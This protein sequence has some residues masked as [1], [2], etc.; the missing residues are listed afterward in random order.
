MIALEEVSPLLG[1]KITRN[2]SLGTVDV[3]FVPVAQTAADPASGEKIARPAAPSYGY[4][5]GWLTSYKEAV[6]QS[7]AS[8][9]PILMDFTGSDWC[10]WCKKLKAE[11]FETNEFKQWAASNV[12][13]L[14][15]DFPRR[16]SQSPAMKQQN[17]ELAQ[18][19]GVR[20]Y[21]T[22]IFATH[23]GQVLG[24][25]GYDEG[26]PAVWTK[27]ASTYLKRR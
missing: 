25:Y 1:L 5:G 24:Q 14:E 16:T 8:G 20:G 6:A 11:V 23:S 15:L 9:K 22:I 3:N 12:V 2:R 7:K 18:K 17:Q 19:F 21:P 13:L 4:G 26:G 10:G 27:N